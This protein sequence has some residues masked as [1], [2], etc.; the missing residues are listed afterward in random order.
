MCPKDRCGRT[1]EQ[2]FILCIAE[3]QGI[4]DSKL[5]K[6]KALGI[7]AIGKPEAE[8]EFIVESCTEAYN[9]VNEKVA[10]GGLP[11]YQRSEI[12]RA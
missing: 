1:T 4:K 10:R 5:I 7:P 9:K 8:P 11:H 3:Q 2:A 6:S 12:N